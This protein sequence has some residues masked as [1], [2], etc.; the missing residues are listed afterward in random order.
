MCDDRHAE[1]GIVAERAQLAEVENGDAAI[2]VVLIIHR[3]GCRLVNIE[4]K[5]HAR[6]L[7]LALPALLFLALAN[8]LDNERM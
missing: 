5:L 3:A 4:R 2:H 6:L 1:A 7:A 8:L